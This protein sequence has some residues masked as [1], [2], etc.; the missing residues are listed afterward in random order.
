MTKIFKIIGGA[1]LIILIFFIALEF[2]SAPK[3][4]AMVQVVEDPNRVGVNPTAEQLDFGDLSRGTGAIRYIDLKNESR[5][6][7][8]IMV[9]KF[10]ELAELLE[11]SRNNFTLQPGAEQRLEFILNIPVSAPARQYQASIWIIRIPNL[12]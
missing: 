2:F 6:D 10:G 12:F 8:I 4:Q 9:L 3:F 11:V 1:A 5:L 7:T